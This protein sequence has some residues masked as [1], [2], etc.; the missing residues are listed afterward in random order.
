MNTRWTQQ[1]IDILRREWRSQTPARII[2]EKLGRPLRAT[3]V[4]AHRLGLPCKSQPSE[5]NLS[6]TDAMW[7]KNNFPHM[8]TKF[9]AMRLGI[10]HRSVI[11]Q[12]RMMGLVKTEKFMKEC[13]EYTSRKA[14]ESHIKNGTYP[15]KGIL[16]EN[17]AKGAPYRFKPGHKPEN[18]KQPCQ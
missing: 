15:P 10:S 13:Q 5:I 11:R 3:Y 17:I 8:A 6:K 9:C 4:K 2:A 16:N 12:A 14:K 18:K 7:L 1:E